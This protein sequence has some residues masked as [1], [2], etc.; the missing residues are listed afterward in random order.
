MLLLLSA[1]TRDGARTNP[2]RNVVFVI[3]DAAGA[4]YFG[5]YG[6]QRP[7][8]P[9]IDAF[10]R[11]ATV[12]ER[13]YSQSAWTLPS[14]GSFMTGGYPP[15]RSITLR[16]DEQETL[17]AV[18]TRN[19]FSTAAFS[20]NPYITETFGV[21]AGFTVFRGFIPP[22][23]LNPGPLHYDRTPNQR[24]ISEALAWLD[25]Q[26]DTRFFLY[27]HLL[28]PHAPY[29]PPAPFAGK[30]D[31]DYS[32]SIHGQ[33][34]TLLEINQGKVQVTQRDI[35][36]LRLQYQE[37]LAFADHR[38]GELLD[39]LVQR[40][41]MDQTLVII[42]ADHGEAF[43]E[44]GDMLHSTTVYEEMIH[45]PLI[46][47]FP[48][49]QPSLPAR[50]NEVVEMRAI[51][52]TICDATEIR[53]CPSSLPVSLLAR[54]QGKQRPL[55]LARSWATGKKA[56][57]AAIILQRHKL[58]ADAKTFE[59]IAFFDLEKDRHEQ[60]NVLSTEPDLVAQTATLLREDTESFASD[61]LKLDPSMQERLRALGYAH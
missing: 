3:L 34:Q 33:P 10:A 15:A 55:P 39:G 19:G 35:D 21:G 18:L 22:D 53:D 38:T 32:G 23:T 48:G 40:G 24:T 56:P 58:I 60:V 41:L 6:N 11:D 45:V 17:A 13:A 16:L 54:L 31:P 27:L 1:C 20:E 50:W 12:F 25:T 46:M 42:A 52:P 44:H 37:N 28:L 8:T 51:F 14:V 59:P 29:D 2:A 5:C 9:R 47:R 49:R 7:T 36:H 57:Q 30:F 4:Q 61:E 43:R 26:R